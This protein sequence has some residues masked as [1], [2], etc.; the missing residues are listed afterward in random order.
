MTVGLAVESSWLIILLKITA[1]SLGL[2]LLAFGHRMPRFSGG[3]FWLSVSLLLSLSLLAGTS[4]L[5]AILA[6]FLLLFAWLWLQDRLPRL[7]MA[8]A[9]LLPLPLFWFSYIYFSGSFSFRPRL[10]L[11]GALLGAIAGALWPRAMLAPLASAM[12]ISLLAWAS[13]FTL[14][15]TRLAVPSLMVC[16][17][18][19]YDLHRQRR[20][21]QY[22]PPSRR[23]AGEILLD[24][25]KWAVAVVGLWLFLALFTPFAAAPDAI[26]NQRLAML[27]APTIGFSPA[28]NFYLSGRARPLAL[29]APR[30]P[31]HR[32]GHGRSAGISLSRGQRTGNPG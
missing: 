11:L 15:F 29:L 17:I 20:R 28:S 30:L 22:S 27:T 8:L 13:P 7:T 16:A 4:Y 21:G 12:G 5:L 6:A 2:F 24:W 10:A 18:Q 32:P 1:A 23:S 9:C 3:L 19:F 26:H 25:R 14:S 31:G